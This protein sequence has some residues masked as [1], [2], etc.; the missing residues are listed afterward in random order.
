M[1]EASS[2]AALL[3]AGAFVEHTLK[4]PAFP[5]PYL[6]LHILPQ[7]AVV[8]QAAPGAD[9]A[10]PAQDGFVHL[11]EASRRVSDQS[12]TCSACK[13]KAISCGWHCRW[14]SCTP[15][16]SYVIT[17]VPCDDTYCTQTLAFVLHG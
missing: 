15:V 6:D 14:R 11:Q 2:K 5:L 1:V 12:S 16:L 17:H 8:L 9:C 3:V 7:H 4:G 10:V 13:G